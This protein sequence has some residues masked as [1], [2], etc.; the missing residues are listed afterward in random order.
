MKTQKLLPT[1]ARSLALIGIVALSA[2][3]ALAAARVIK[4]TGTDA[5]KYNLAQI[6]AKP[7]EELTVQVTGIGTQD[8]AVMAHNFVL[9][10]QGTDVNAFVVAASVARPTHIPKQEKWKKAILASTNLAGGGETVSVTF[11]APAKAGAYTYVCTFPGHYNGGM[12]G[13]LTVK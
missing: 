9:L 11:K 8:K 6:T 10:A 13:V 4:L 5:M 12:K 7:G 2:S 3:P 1:F